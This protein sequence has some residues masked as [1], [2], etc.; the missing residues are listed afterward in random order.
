MSYQPMLKP[1]FNRQILT[2][3]K[4]VSDGSVS[5]EKDHVNSITT[6]VHTLR[7]IISIRGEKPLDLSFDEHDVL[8]SVRFCQRFHDC[9]SQWEK[10]MDKMAMI[11]AEI[12]AK[13]LAHNYLGLKDSITVNLLNISL[14]FIIIGEDS[15]SGPGINGIK[16]DSP[17][18]LLVYNSTY[19]N[20]NNYTVSEISTNYL[21]MLLSHMDTM[22]IHYKTI[23]RLENNILSYEKKIRDEQSLIEDLLERIK[24][25][26]SKTQKTNDS[27]TDDKHRERTIQELDAEIKALRKERSTESQKLFI[28]RRNNDNTTPDGSGSTQIAQLEATKKIES[29]DKKILN[30]EELIRIAKDKIEKYKNNILECEEEITKLKKQIK[31]YT[32]TKNDFSR[33]IV[34]MFYKQSNMLRFNYFLHP[35][36]YPSLDSNILAKIQYSQKN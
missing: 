35:D 16:T 22:V 2:V 33:K 17:I 27:N 24:K 13:Y 26:E 6:F 14:S 19:H 3:K 21:N 28:Q 34:N 31:E 9:K 12:D 25:I 8:T 18:G 7:K 10:M 36:Y 32:E 20:N 1:T 29:I 30:N 4:L 15:T 5:S 23:P 11:T